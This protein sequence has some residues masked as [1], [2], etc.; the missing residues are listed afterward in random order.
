MEPPHITDRGLYG[1]STVFRT[2]GDPFYSF[3][4]L[5]TKT[6]SIAKQR[7]L[8]PLP[9]PLLLL[10]PFSGAKRDTH[11]VGGHS[12]RGSHVRDRHAAEKTRQLGECGPTS[13]FSRHPK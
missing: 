6:T 11:G 12:L 5:K 4:E 13:P 1:I 9:L 3:C 10:P 8:L 7:E 2:S